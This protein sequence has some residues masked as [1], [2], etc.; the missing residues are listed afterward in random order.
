MTK[1]SSRKVLGE[2]IYLA[3]KEDILNVDLPPGTILEEM[4]LM[5]RFKVSRTPIREAIRRLVA[6]DLV[7]LEPHRSAYVKNVTFDEISDF[8]EAYR[9]MQ[10]LVFILS[11]DRISKVQVQ[12]IAELNTK[13]SIAFA[14]QDIAAIRKLNDRFYT[15]IAEGCSNR[16]MHDSYT[17]LREFAAR[18]SAMVHKAL[19]NDDWETHASTLQ[20]DHEE[21][22]EALSNKD[23]AS[24]GKISDQD[25]ALFKQ[26]VLRVFERPVPPNIRTKPL[27]IIGR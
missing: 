19:I 17:K 22:I 1:V 27:A 16:F 24:I 5:G 20:R 10:R 12:A 6:N 4:D 25:V 26:K 18:L 7:G 14:K 13:M 11:A 3:L 15:M 9:L 2:D 8:F 21:I 23:C